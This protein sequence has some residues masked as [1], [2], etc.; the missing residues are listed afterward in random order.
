MNTHVVYGSWKL[1]FDEPCDRTDLTLIEVPLP[2]QPSIVCDI[3]DLPVLNRRSICDGTWSYNTAVHS[4]PNLNGGDAPLALANV[5]GDT[6]VITHLI[7]R[8]ETHL[9]HFLS[10]PTGAHSTSVEELLRS[11]RGLIDSNHLNFNNFEC[12]YYP[13]MT[14]FATRHRVAPEM[15]AA[16]AHSFSERLADGKVEGFF[17]QIGKELGTREYRETR[18]RSVEPHDE[19]DGGVLVSRYSQTKRMHQEQRLA[20]IATLPDSAADGTVFSE[21]VELP[22]GDEKSFLSARYQIPLEFSSERLTREVRI[23]VE[24]SSG[25]LFEVVFSSHLPEGG[26]LESMHFVSINSAAVRTMA[27]MDRVGTEGRV[28]ER[29]ILSMMKGRS[30]QNSLNL[31]ANPHDR[32][33]RRMAPRI[34]LVGPSG[35]GKST[36]AAHLKNRLVSQGYGAVVEKLAM[37]LYDLQHAMYQRMGVDLDYTEQDQHLLEELAR[38]F[39]RIDPRFLVRDF[40]SRCEQ[41]VDLAIINDD[42]RDV[43]TDLP[44]L[45]SVGFLCVQI[46]ADDATRASRLSL[47]GDRTLVKGSKLDEEL[48]RMA[49]DY[50]IENNGCVDEF[51]RAL[52]TLLDEMMGGC[53]EIVTK[54]H[55]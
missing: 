51:N 49:P 29:C 33:L 2:D 31:N 9:C 1:R 35:S 47:R 48:N 46:K 42:L 23:G 17:R 41:S 20:T 25:V 38:Q 22:S 27:V 52:D 26:D 40:L 53:D 8:V 55:Y 43:A 24:S 36:A 30:K 4:A 45:R 21:E 16:L 3:Q 44:A 50:V 12:G 18:Y 13:T 37:P 54:A 7:L 39:R 6:I 15:I 28:L 10:P 32:L 14:A 11:L 5:D 19:S 34:A